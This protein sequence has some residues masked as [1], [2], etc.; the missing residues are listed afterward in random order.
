MNDISTGKVIVVGFPGM[1]RAVPTGL[2]LAAGS[3]RKENSS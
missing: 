1:A 2:R 3:E